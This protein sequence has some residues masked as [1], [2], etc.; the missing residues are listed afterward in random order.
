M[1]WHFSS[2]KQTGVFYYWLRV[3]TPCIFTYKYIIWISLHKKT[4]F[5]LNQAKRS[6]SQIKA[7][8]DTFY[9]LLKE[10]RHPGLLRPVDWWRP[11]CFHPVLLQIKQRG[12]KWC[13]TER[14]GFSYET[15]SKWF[16]WREETSPPSLDLHPVSFHSVI[17]GETSTSS[18]ASF[19]TSFLLKECACDKQFTSYSVLLP[20]STK[21]SVRLLCSHKQNSK[22][23]PRSYCQS[24]YDSRYCWLID[25]WQ[26]FSLLTSYLND[27][28]SEPIVFLFF[29]SH[30]L[31]ST[32]K[33]KH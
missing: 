28:S 11:M 4:V 22:I 30:K 27:I 5:C 13:L 26:L 25:N 1:M 12:R 20:L 15:S 23:R 6:M 10:C 24:N 21:L 14:L 33:R 9:S 16:D 31:F 29:L 32:Q 7:V 17:S 19:R 8:K 3:Y 2:L 18:S